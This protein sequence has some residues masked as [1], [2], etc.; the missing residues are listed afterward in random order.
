MH[1][2]RGRTEGFSS[3]VGLY[4]SYDAKDPRRYL[5]HLT[6]AGLGLP[7]RDYYPERGRARGGHSSE[8]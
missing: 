5:P 1:F 8:V 2:G 3:P 6:Q 4:V 7:D